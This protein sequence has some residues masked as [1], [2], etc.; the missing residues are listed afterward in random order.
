MWPNDDVTDGTR[1][2]ERDGR[3]VRNTTNL[4]PLEHNGIAIMLCGASIRFLE[5]ELMRATSS[6]ILPG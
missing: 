5:G 4:S 6:V 2:S 1:L 3:H